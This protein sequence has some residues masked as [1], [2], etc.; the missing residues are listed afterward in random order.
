MT[1]RFRQEILAIEP[2]SPGKPIDEVQREYGLTDVIKLASNENP[3][4]PGPLAVSALQKAAADAHLYPDGGCSRLRESI[5]ARLGIAKDQVIVGNGSDE[6]LKLAAEVFLSQSDSAVMADPTFSEYQ[7]AT[8]LMGASVRRVPLKD[9]RHDLKAMAAA[10]DDS[11]RIAFVCNPNNP[12][13]TI[14]SHVEFK[15]FLDSV[16]SDVLVV[17][18]EAYV[19]YAQD[20]AFP[21]ALELL[22]EYTNLLV[23]RT[24]SKLHG[25][26]GLRVGYG[27]GHA[28]LINL[29]HRVREP[30]N[31][32]AFGQAAAVAALQDSE[33]AAQSVQVN[34]RG[35]AFLYDVFASLELS[36][37][38]TQTNFVLVDVGR[39]SQ[40]IFEQL[41]IRGII[42]RA[43]HSFGLPTHLRITVGTEAQNRRLAAGLQ[44][45]L[46]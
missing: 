42:V 33:H 3:L 36:F 5:A 29:M 41:L 40:E 20:P 2:Y 14:V 35:K 23:T 18:D 6:L 19:E 25:L 7:F 39:D 27:I 13:G 37:I 45:V 44:E 24:F 16:P 15:E 10:V 26:A 4:G 46:G 9:Y 12:T 32:N 1:T 38:Q 30:F 21:Q 31:V 17:L 22:R 11:T 8:R 34:E 43:A 28:D